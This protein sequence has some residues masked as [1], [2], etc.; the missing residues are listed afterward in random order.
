MAF[1][2]PHHKQLADL[3]KQDRVLRRSGSLRSLIDKAS[4]N[5]TVADVVEDCLPMQF[6]EQITVV[7][8]EKQTLILSFPGAAVA[9]QF[10][11]QLD[12][13]L[14]MVQQRLGPS[15]VQQIKIKIRP[16]SAR[17]K[18]VQAKPRHLSKK[19]A[20][21]LSEVAGQTSDETLRRAL[22]KLAQHADQA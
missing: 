20:Q 13:T 12:T 19:N 18:G 3:I 1:K 4:A 14:K 5:K 21:L 15:K 10:R 7:G 17:K 2:Q 9:T 11:F 8:I 6:R 16:S 22:E